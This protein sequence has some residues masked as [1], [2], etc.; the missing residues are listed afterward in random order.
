MIHLKVETTKQKNLFRKILCL[1]L[2][3]L[4]MITM[5]SRCKTPVEVER[6]NPIDPK[7]E[8]FAPRP[9]DGLVAQ[10]QDSLVFLTW[11]DHSSYE[12]G[13][14]I[15]RQIDQDTTYIEIAR[16]GPNTVTFSDPINYPG[17]V[18]TYRVSAFVSYENQIRSHGSQEKAII[19]SNFH[20]QTPKVRILDETRI[21]I[22]WN[23]PFTF[24]TAYEVE[25]S[26]R[27]WLVRDFE[28]MAVL[29]PDSRVYIDESNFPNW[30][31]Y[32]YRIRAV[33]KQDKSPYTRRNQID[34]DLESPRNLKA[35]TFPFTNV[36]KLT[37]KRHPLAVAYIVERREAPKP[38]FTHLIQLPPDSLA[39]HDKNLNSAVEKYSY[40]VRTLLSPTSANV[41]I[42]YERTMVPTN[43]LGEHQ[44]VVTEVAFTPDAQ[45]IFT[46]SAD[47]TVRVWSAGTG[48]LLQTIPL[49]GFNALSVHSTQPWL[50]TA[51]ANGVKVW[52]YETGKLVKQIDGAYPFIAA[53]SSEG[54]Y[55]G[56]QGAWSQLL[57]LD[58]A[59]WTTFQTIDV[60]HQR[61]ILGIAFTFDGKRVIS[62]DRGGFGQLYNIDTGEHIR[63]FEGST[64]TVSCLAFSAD[65]VLLV[66]NGG[67]RNGNGYLYDLESGQ[68]LWAN[69]ENSRIGELFFSPDGKV[70]V[71]V[72]GGLVKFW[73]IATR[74]LVYRAEAVTDHILSAAYSPDGTTLATG[75]RSGRV[76]LWQE[77]MMWLPK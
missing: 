35:S 20:K 17:F 49:P 59:T 28:R 18:A 19:P 16:L 30:Q 52:D 4:L 41:S 42:Q 72:T 43:E 31:R 12:D 53:F 6:D 11:A 27:T 21:E 70:L 33:H 14:L 66:S 67:T 26:Y 71:T 57:I 38:S 46:G 48:Q 22:S 73:D 58:I 10:I 69:W 9:P 36:V 51:A 63:T 5:L 56:I 77:G 23:D 1:S 37:W 54:S 25:R 62:G 76:H 13:Y 60:P 29:P 8:N 55:L 45:K 34:I 74:E 40:R 2:L 61:G 7:N 3:G 64:A 47:H 50:V 15:E 32:Y 24:E 65:D 44:N 68:T 39:F 75:S